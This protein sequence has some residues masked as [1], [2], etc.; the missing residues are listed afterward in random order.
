MDYPERQLPDGRF[1]IVVPLTFGRARLMIGKS[2]W[3]YDD[4]Y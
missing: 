2:P 4:S 1:M 3:V